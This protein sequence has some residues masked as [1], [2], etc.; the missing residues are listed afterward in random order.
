MIQV[1]TM[2]DNRQ[3]N[4]DK[5][6]KCNINVVVNQPDEL[7]LD[8][9]NHNYQDVA[10]IEELFTDRLDLGTDIL[11][12]KLL[13]IQLQKDFEI[14]PKYNGNKVS[15]ETNPITDDAYDK[16]PLHLNYTMKFNSTEEAEKFRKNGI[17]ELI[18]LAEKTGKP[19]EIPNITS[20]KE[21]LGEFEN[22]VGHANKYGSEGIKLY[23][24]PSPLPPAQVYTID[25]F[26]SDYSFCIDTSLK[27]DSKN[28][29]DIKL[30]NK[31]SID[32]PFNVVI[33]LKNMKKTE[34]GISGQFNITLSLR[35][36]CLNDCEYNLKLIKYKYLIDDINNN[37][38]IT[39]KELNQQVFFF[40]NCG[41]KK[42]NKKEEK[43]FKRL[44]DLLEKVIYI[45]K[46]K[47]IK[48][49]Y[50]LD[51]F[52]REENSINI[53]Y[54]ECNNKNCKIKKKMNFDSVV[55]VNDYT[56]EF[57]NQVDNFDFISSLNFVNLFGTRIELK[58]NELIAK[59]CKINK[60]DKVDK[61]YHVSLSS[62]D[63][64]FKINKNKTI[65]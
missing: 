55:E 48:I 33:S 34:E 61:M 43:N 15:F 40:N 24:C 46:V 6:K 59:N 44:I 3:I 27:L 39:N 18:E 65:K 62:D 26:N 10:K 12:K 25:I 42:H 7:S 49:K 37:I 8:N 20:M 31:D 13:P 50:D 45:G 1:I 21:F 41:G 23:I 22:P 35:D 63:I 11:T 51:E 29:E 14:V 9:I 38:N 17:N 57:C 54:A 16:Y 30:T 60:V 2:K 32:E 19:V 4:I 56:T 5:N 58:D 52:L 36:K 53:V 64:S 28:K 47:N